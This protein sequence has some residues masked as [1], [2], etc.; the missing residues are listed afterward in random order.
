MVHAFLGREFGAREQGRDGGVVHFFGQAVAAQQ[1]LLAGAQFARQGFD[2]QAL[3]VGD[4]QGLGDHVAVRVH[5]RL[6]G[7]DGALVDQFLH[8]AVVGRELAQLAVPQVGAAV[9]DPAHLEAVLGDAQGHHGG[10]HRQAFRALLAVP[11]D[12]FVGAADGVHQRPPGAHLAHHGVAGQRAGDL[13]EFVAAHAVGH[14][15]QAQLGVAVVGVFVELATQADV[16]QVAEFDH[17]RCPCLAGVGVSSIR[18]IMRSPRAGLQAATQ[19]SIRKPSAR[20]YC[21]LRSL[22]IR[23]S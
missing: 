5:A 3:R 8:V 7:G 18:D 10:A 13:A 12:V 17:A 16:A 15:P 20:L 9:A 4:A 1:Q 22:P 2:L 6:F 23:R 19:N 14:Q 11:D 21:E